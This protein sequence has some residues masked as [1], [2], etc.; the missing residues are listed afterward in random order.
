MK[1]RGLDGSRHCITTFSSPVGETFNHVVVAVLMPM[2]V[3]GIL[4]NILTIYVIATSPKLKN[5]FNIFIMSLC[6]SDLLS[7]LISP[8][9]VYSRVWGRVTWRISLFLCKV[10]WGGNDGTSVATSLHIVGFSYMRLCA[11]TWPH[12]YRKFTV[13]H[14]KILVSIIWIAALGG[15]FVPTAIWAEVITDKNKRSPSCSIGSKWD[16]E[17]IGYTLIGFPIFFYLPMVLVAISSVALA[18]VLFKK[19]EKRKR[20][21]DA[22]NQSEIARQRKENQAIVQLAFVVGSFMIGYVPYTAFYVS[23]KMIEHPRYKM[24]FNLWFSTIAFMLLRLSECLNPILYN[25]TSRSIRA[26]TMKVLKKF[27]CCRSTRISNKSIEFPPTKTSSSRRSK[28]C[29]RA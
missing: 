27:Q 19:R 10:L 12:K 2:A 7:S 1:N 11:V 6:F 13:S 26:E 8:L 28:E 3:F 23:V 18:V 20:L 21:R 29:G 22:R 16:Q 5:T 9:W 15:G 14:A 24:T 17:F 4:A 25:L